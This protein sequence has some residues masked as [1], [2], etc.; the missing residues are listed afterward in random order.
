MAQSCPGSSRT[1]ES[2]RLT[3]AFYYSLG[4]INLL[5]VEKLQQRRPRNFAAARKAGNSTAKTNHNEISSLSVLA[6][7]SRAL[8]SDEILRL[9]QFPGPVASLDTR[10]GRNGARSMPCEIAMTEQPEHADQAE[11]RDKV[12]QKGDHTQYERPSSQKQTN[13]S[14]HRADTP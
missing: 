5:P 1:S 7:T 6:V 11:K 3:G 9:L 8:M 13:E 10:S 12:Q 4:S 2:G 14:E